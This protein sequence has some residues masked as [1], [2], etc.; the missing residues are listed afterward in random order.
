V[1]DSLRERAGV[2]LADDEVLASA[3]LWIGSVDALLEKIVRLREELGISS[4]MLG[5]PDEMMPIVQ[6]LAGG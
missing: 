3:H 6:R 1:A 5:D 4:F 2:D